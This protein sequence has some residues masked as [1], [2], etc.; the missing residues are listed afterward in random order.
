[1]TS[2]RHHLV[3]C[4]MI[5]GCFSLTE[6]HIPKENKG[7]RL[8]TT[9]WC[10]ALFSCYNVV[11]QDCEVMIML[12]LDFW[13]M[14][15][16]REEVSFRNIYVW[17]RNKSINVSMLVA[18]KQLYMQKWF[19]KY[20][21]ETLFKDDNVRPK[22]KRQLCKIVKPVSRSTFKKVSTFF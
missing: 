3:K 22:E 8:Y 5:Y 21:L 19:K 2:E 6:H 16:S 1:M 9:S 20:Q 10:I 17:Y 14:L 18:S 15:C 13:L 4:A 11:Q 12:D 7:L